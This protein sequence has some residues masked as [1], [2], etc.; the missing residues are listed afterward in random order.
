MDICGKLPIPSREIAVRALRNARKHEKSAEGRK[1]LHIY[2]CTDGHDG[3]HVG[4]G[5]LNGRITKAMKKRA[6]P[7]VARVIPLGS[8]TERW[9]RLLAMRGN[10]A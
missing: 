10:I 5:M 7:P 3:W 6:K 1:R 8:F 2:H 9:E 4:Q